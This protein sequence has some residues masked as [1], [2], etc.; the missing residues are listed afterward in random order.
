MSVGVCELAGVNGHRI[1]RLGISG[2]RI[3]LRQFVSEVVRIIGDEDQGETRSGD[4]Y[5]AGVIGIASDGIDVEISRQSSIALEIFSK[6]LVGPGDVPRRGA[7]RQEVFYPH[8]RRRSSGLP[9]LP[10]SK[11]EGHDAH[12]SGTR[13][14]NVV[15][16]G[17]FGEH[18]VLP[19]CVCGGIGI[20][21]VGSQVENAGRAGLSEGLGKDHR[22]IEHRSD[23]PL[24]VSGLGG[25]RGVERVIVNVLST[26]VEESFGKVGVRHFERVIRGP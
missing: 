13:I 24:M 2:S 4:A 10:T 18:A 1:E 12:G 17:E 14:R 21:V 5:S 19:N 8:S 6:G 15:E 26:N 16:Q 25:R 9:G 11:G 7:V 20:S 3:C 22:S 23:A